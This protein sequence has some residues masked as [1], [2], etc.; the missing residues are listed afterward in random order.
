MC[1]RDRL[2]EICFIHDF[3]ALHMVPEI[4]CSHMEIAWFIKKTKPSLS[5]NMQMK[6]GRGKKSVYRWSTHMEKA[7]LK[8]SEGKFLRRRLQWKKMPQNQV[9]FQ[10]SIAKLLE[11]TLHRKAFIVSLFLRRDYVMLLDCVYIHYYCFITT[12]FEKN[13][14]RCLWMCYDKTSPCYL[15]C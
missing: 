14:K 8:L 1:I 15:K 7:A 10:L 3:I 6:L 5:R 4:P 2:R 12:L 11:P 13:L 9:R